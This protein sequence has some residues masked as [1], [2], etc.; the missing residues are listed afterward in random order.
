MYSTSAGDLASQGYVVITV[1]H[2]YDA[3]I[4]EFPDGSVVR[5]ANFSTLAAIQKTLEVRPMPRPLA[6]APR[7]VRARPSLSDVMGWGPPP[8][9]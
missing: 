8:P 2:P 7:S 5:G 6:T 4:V 9:A 3:A 1:D